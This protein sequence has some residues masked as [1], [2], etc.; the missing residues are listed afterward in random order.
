MGAEFSSAIPFLVSTAGGQISTRFGNGGQTPERIQ[1][2]PVEGWTMIDVQTK[3]RIRTTAILLGMLAASV[4]GLFFYSV[5]A[6]GG[7]GS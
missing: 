2:L 5:L 4:L 1:G 6:A 7:L 3:K